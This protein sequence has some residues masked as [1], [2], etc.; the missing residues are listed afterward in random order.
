MTNLDEFKRNIR[1]GTVHTAAF[2]VP[3]FLHIFNTK[4]LIVNKLRQNELIYSSLYHF[5]YRL[6]LRKNPTECFSFSFCQIIL[7][8]LCR[9]YFPPWAAEVFYRIRRHIQLIN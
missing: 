8:F 3:Y 5:S 1:R 6:A 2:C 7:Y 4:I 9:L